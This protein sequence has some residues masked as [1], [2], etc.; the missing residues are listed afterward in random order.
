MQIIGVSGSLRAESGNTR[1]LFA[2]TQ[3]APVDVDFRLTS[4]V[5]NLPLFNP[6]LDPSGIAVVD[7]WVREIRAA[8]GIV[9][10][11]PEYARGYPGALKNAFDWLV[12]TDAYV[13]KPFM[14]LNASSRSTVARETFSV[15]LETMSGIHI[16]DASTTLHILGTKLSAA[17]IV[18]TLEFADRISAAMITFVAGIT[19]YL[20]SIVD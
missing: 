3:L 1:L 11:T 15:V 14:L 2:A 19:E 4:S 6:D 20:D 7:E 8:D 10:S 12:G 16:R 17:E 5:A 9:V 18:G 13:N